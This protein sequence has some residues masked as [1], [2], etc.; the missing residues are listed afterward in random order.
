MSKIND[1]PPGTNLGGVKFLH[2]E[3]REICYW[4]SQWGKGV[5]YRK[6]LYDSQ[7]FPIFLED[8]AEAKEFEL[9]IPL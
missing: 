4:V 5:W 7:I 8:L 9:A 1:L 3:T 2:P 6:D